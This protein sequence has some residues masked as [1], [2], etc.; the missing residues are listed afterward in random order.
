MD[1][2]ELWGLAGSG[3]LLSCV[4]MVL[5]RLKPANRKHRLAGFGL[6]AVSLLPLAGGISAAGF[7]R[8]YFG[9]LSAT[10]L[11]LLLLYLSGSSR[12]TGNGR[13]YFLTLVCLGGL[14]LYPLTLGPCR[15][16]PYEWGYRP[17][18]L[19]SAI[20]VSGL[21]MARR[22]PAAV[23]YLTFPL[24]AYALNLAASNNLWDYLLDPLV[25][26]YATVALIRARQRRRGNTG[27]YL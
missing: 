17:W 8:G 3:L 26:G 1:L 10:T 24:L 16:D 2:Q 18:W 4:V 23:I 19:L 25:F 14:V 5:C 11:L 6:L 9:D 27:Q 13:T 7:V 12:P 20:G 15:L 21:A 22:Q